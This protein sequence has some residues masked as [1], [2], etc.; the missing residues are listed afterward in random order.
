MR[1]TLS[2]PD[3]ILFELRE[4]ARARRTSLTRVVADTLRAGLLAA[5]T[6]KPGRRPLVPVFDLGKP[7]VDLDQ[8][9]RLAAEMEDEEILRKMEAGK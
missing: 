5:K 4:L 1:T 3:D 2:I 8:A 9:L 6:G 7:R